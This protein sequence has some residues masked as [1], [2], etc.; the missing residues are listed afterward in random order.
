MNISKRTDKLMLTVVAGVGIG[1]GLALL[2]NPKL[3]KEVREMVEDATD[4]AVRILKDVAREAIFR[5]SRKI[6]TSICNYDG[7]GLFV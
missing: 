6:D 7:G 3:V 1:T 5:V 2:R 4:D